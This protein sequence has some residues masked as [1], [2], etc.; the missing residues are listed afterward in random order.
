MK[1]VKVIRE[2]QKQIR[3]RNGNT[4]GSYYLQEDAEDYVRM[5]PCCL[6][7]TDAE[8]LVC[9]KCGHQLTRRNVTPGYQ[10]YCPNCDE[11]LYGIEARRR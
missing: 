6:E 5:E 11:D 9:R 3:A 7:E 1:D 2:V 4:I 8:G 10:F